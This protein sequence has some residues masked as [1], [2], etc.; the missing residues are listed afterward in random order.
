MITITKAF[1][2]D[3]LKV[4]KETVEKISTENI[5]HDKRVVT[6]KVG[7]M[8]EFVEKYEFERKSK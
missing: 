6:G 5:S 2:I 4:I 8:I 1:I 3:N 7:R